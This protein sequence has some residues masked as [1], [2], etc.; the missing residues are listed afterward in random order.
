MTALRNRSKRWLWVSVFIIA[1]ALLIFPNLALA[2]TTLD[3]VIHTIIP[4]PSP[5]GGTDVRIF[6]SV[7]D[8]E[9]KMVKNLEKGDFT[10]TESGEE[11][12]VKSLSQ[13]RDEPISILILLDT[14][15]NS[16]RVN[17]EREAAVDFIKNL[18]RDDFVGVISFAD[19]EKTDVEITDDHDKA[20]E[21]TGSIKNIPETGTCYFDAAYE[22]VKQIAKQGG[23]RAIILITDS[24]DKAYQSSISCSSNTEEDV[25]ESATDWNTRVPIYT[26]GVSESADEKSLERLA[27]RTGGRYIYVENS[28]DIKDALNDF[29]NQFQNE[30]ILTYNTAGKPGSYTIVVDVE[31]KSTSDSDTRAMEIT[32]KGS[33][34]PVQSAASQT[35]ASESAAAA[36]TKAALPTLSFEATLPAAQPENGE[37]SLFS[38]INPILLVGIAAVIAA[39]VILLVVFAIA[40]R[41]LAGGKKK[42]SGVPAAVPSGPAP[43]ATIDSFPGVGALGA[44]QAGAQI[45]SLTIL[46]SDDAAMVGKVLIVNGG[47]T[48]IG[49]S[50]ENDL[51]L[52]GEKAV[53]REHAII[54]Q[55][56]EHIFLAEVISQNADRSVKRP[57]YGTF[58]NE[59]KV[60]GVPVEIQNGDEIRLG[61][62]LR[63]RF[64]KLIQPTGSDATVDEVNIPSSDKTVDGGGETVEYHQ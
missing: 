63:M 10:I 23:Q 34:L 3:L 22:A 50:S 15:G 48:S 56:G 58:I 31:H 38:G 53:S 47:R 40:R 36:P 2:K 49:R 45:G 19:E 28:G 6:L 44:A 62:R 57:T 1:L 18:N 42:T 29:S 5:E 17:E 20:Q 4:A 32:E 60:E 9:R 64:E 39:L 35:P 41:I 55:S 33:A 11:M 43:D 13:V 21:R 8:D 61:T 51:V 52:A 37:T 25:I 26:V 27:D 7:W 14:S 59:V 24:E 30:Y 46:A 16:V 54:E 12:E